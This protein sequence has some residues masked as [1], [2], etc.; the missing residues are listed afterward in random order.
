MS[1][2]GI[3]AAARALFANMTF[4]HLHLHTEYSL[5]DGFANIRKLMERVE[6]MGM[7]AVAITD[8]GTMYGVIEFYN[9]AKERGIKPIIGLE[10]YLSPRGMHDMDPQQD[11]TAHHLLLLAENDTGY[12]NLLQI[13]SAAQLEG[14]YYHPRIDHEYLATHSAGLICTSGCMASEIP[15]TLQERGAKAVRAKL[16]WYYQVFGKD[17]FFLELQRHDI[18]ELEQI[19]R[20]LVELGPHYQARYVATNDTHYIDPEDARYQDIMLC[21]QTGSLLSDPKRMRMTGNTYYLRSPREMQNLFSEVPESISNTLLIAERC[22]VDLDRKGYHMPDFPVP[23]GC[24]AQTYLR[25]LC[26]EGLRKRYGE[27]VDDET[28]HERL[29]Y[30]LNIIHDMGFD[31]YFLIVWDLCCHARQKGIWYAT[32]GSGNGSIV[33]YT[34]EI[35]QV[36]PIAQ[37]LLFERFLNSGRQEMPDIDLDFQD[38]RRAEMMAYCAQRYGDDRVAQIITFGTL[39]AKAAIRDVG[40]VKDIPLSE[41]DRIA[42]LVPFMAQGKASALPE[43]MEEVPEFREAVEAADYLK[44]LVENSIHVEGVLRNAGTHAAGVVITDKPITEYA[45]LNRPTSGSQETPIKSVVQFEMS[46]ISHLGLLK[47]DFLGLDTLTI[48]SRACELI[49]ARHGKE[50]DLSSIPINDPDAFEF[51]GKGHTQGLFQLEGSGMTRYITQMKPKTLANII[52]MVALYRP[53]PMQFIPQ[54]I[55]CMHG[56]EKVSYQHPKLEAVFGETYGVG[57]YQEQ[58]MSAAMLLAGY[59]P[60]DADDLRSAISKKKKEA[61]E[62]HHA[63]FI[64]G[65]VKNGIS[66]EKAARIFKDWE[67][68]ARYGFNKSHAAAYGVLAVQTAFLK[69]HYP[70]EY[71]TALLSARKTDNDRTAMYVADCRSMGIEVLPPDVNYSDWDFTIEDHS[72]GIS[73]IRF[74]LGA[75]KNVGNAPVDVIIKARQE[76]GAFKNLADFINR[77]DQRQIGKRALE[78]LIKVGALDSMAPREALLEAMD[79]IVNVSSNHFKQ[80]ECGQLSFFSGMEDTL[81]QVRL[82][83]VPFPDKN[84]YLEW[85]RELLGLY[86]SDHPLKPYAGALKKCSTCSSAELQDLKPHAKVKLAGMISAFR[87]TRT[88]KGDPMAFVT[89]EDLTGKTELIVFPRVWEEYRLTIRN[90]AVICAE[91]SLGDKEGDPKVLVDKISEL[92]LVADTAAAANSEGTPSGQNDL[93]SAEGDRFDEPLDLHGDDLP[94]DIPWEDEGPENYQASADA[95]SVTVAETSTLVLEAPVV[96]AQSAAPPVNYILPV[97]QDKSKHH[98]QM[99]TVVIRS[100]GEKDRDVRRLSRLLGMLSS[101]PGEDRVVLR[102]FEDGEEYLMEF[103][104]ISISIC[105]DLLN[106]IVGII[107]SDEFRIENVDL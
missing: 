82:I 65:C 93:P 35:S 90:G 22:E 80:K 5:L 20:T 59:S 24:N 27:V 15:R 96:T 60:T 33:A 63:L 11:R 106:R 51:I 55:N 32:R 53:G 49:K 64:E 87:A 76:G 47:V 36:D 12:R 38:D 67:G 70:V 45:P 41:V 7:P 54:Y 26:E 2:V 50:Y 73:S 17:N 68:F 91:G 83:S 18:P 1:V 57:I 52:A 30:E 97:S 44:D 58:I 34:L 4:A 75:I 79:T 102:I 56:V 74:G 94:N 6:E 29:D 40:R 69:C 81:E 48:I 62:K 19:N 39:G 14:F 104:N 66:K 100:T 95:Q 46:I 88:K 31:S 92:Q 3:K 89:L 99:L 13:A 86:V 103:P 43:I 28:T 61:V 77:V 105:D 42:K 107:G 10:A 9:R 84:M 16:D 71:M 78:F 21:I 37:G 25:S 72:E 8:H 98:C 85:E 23:E 101:C